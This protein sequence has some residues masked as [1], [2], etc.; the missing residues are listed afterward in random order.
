VNCFAQQSSGKTVIL[1]QQ[2]V[3]FTTCRKWSLL[4]TKMNV[5]ATMNAGN[6]PVKCLVHDMLVG[7]GRIIEKHVTL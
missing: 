1:I 5:I 4:E 2:D 3:F 7:G 6:I